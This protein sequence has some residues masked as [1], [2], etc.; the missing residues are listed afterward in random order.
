MRITTL[1][2]GNEKYGLPQLVANVLSAHD[3]SR[4]QTVG[5]YLGDGED[6]HSRYSLCGLPARL[7]RPVPRA[8]ARR[9]V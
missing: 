8:P 4:V 6:A 1:L 9:L 2:D 3:S 7:A 5:L